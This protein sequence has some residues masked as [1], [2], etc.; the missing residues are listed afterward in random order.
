MK[1][2]TKYFL[3]ALSLLVTAACGITAYRYAGTPAAETPHIALAAPETRRAPRPVTAS[4]R[5]VTTTDDIRREY[6][7]LEV[8]TLRD[9]R[10]YRGAVIT[11][12][13]IYEMVTVNGTVRFAMS[14][15]QARDI[16]R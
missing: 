7:R 11:T 14:D 2:R 13:D 16:V 9:G 12:S 4:K 3:A 10:Q 6:G 5:R 8:V 15:I 1:Y